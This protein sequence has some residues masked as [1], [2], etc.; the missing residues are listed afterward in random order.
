MNASAKQSSHDDWMPCTA[1]KQKKE[2]QDLGECLGN[3]FLGRSW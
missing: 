2:N 3:V 1:K